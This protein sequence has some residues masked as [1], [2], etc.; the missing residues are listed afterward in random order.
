M[1]IIIETFLN[2]LLERRYMFTK[3][4]KWLQLTRQQA[5]ILGI[6]YSLQEQN[7]PTNPT[8]IEKAYFRENKTF[9]QKSNLFTQLK[10]LQEKN[11][12]AKA[13]QSNYVLNLRGIQEAIFAQKKELSAEVDEITKFASDTQAFFEKVIKPTATVVTYLTQEELY[14]RLTFYLKSA[15]SFY[16]GCEFP[17]YSYSFALCKNAQEAAYVEMLTVRIQNPLFSLFCLSPYKIE[18]LSYRLQEKYKNKELVKEELRNIIDNTQ[19]ITTQCKNIDLR[20]S[21]TPFNFALIENPEESNALFM[22]LKD[23]R[24]QVTG[25]IFINSYETTKQTKQHFLSQMGATPALKK[26]DDFP[27]FTETDLLPLPETN[28]KKLIAFDVNRI[29]TV[30]H[31]TVELANLVGR[32]KEVLNFIVD[33]IEGRISMQEAI[34]ESAKLLKGLSI[35]EIENAIPKIQLMKNVQKGIL[36]L[37]EKNYHLVAISSGF[38]QIVTPICKALGI[39]EIYCNVLGEKDGKITGE[40]LEKNVLTDDVKYYIVK[41][42]QERLSIP[43]ERSIGVGDGYSDIPL[44]KST[45]IRICF[46]P[47]QKMK[48]LFRDGDAAITHLV[49]EQD[50]M[51]LV[52]RIL[53]EDK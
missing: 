1:V 39:D 50:F 11:L 18:G 38:N 15:T 51:K 10:I 52:S 7:A 2:Y 35:K 40:V 19:R 37:K 8:S 32:E 44:L 17:H 16:L 23:S 13:E 42:V 14:K 53:K 41:Y 22:F 24:G 33:Q 5:A 4:S 26:E 48:S 21:P 29:F 36:K 12:L 31:T 9:I 43:T 28:K 30:N 47:S 20:K 45:K 34:L 49:D 27:F 3:L 25:G 6:T 46:N